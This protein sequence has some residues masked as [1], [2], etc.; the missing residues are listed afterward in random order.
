MG[1]EQAALF[2]ITLAYLDF[3]TCLRPTVQ[4]P[5]VLNTNI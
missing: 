3:N 1:T 2:Y 5:L 4:N